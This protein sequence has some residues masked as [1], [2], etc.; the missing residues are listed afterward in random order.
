MKNINYSQERQYNI[1]RWF[2]KFVDAE[3]LT[4]DEYHAFCKWVSG[5]QRGEVLMWV[6]EKQNPLKED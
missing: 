1:N 4:K 6:I 5:R 2:Q 3:I